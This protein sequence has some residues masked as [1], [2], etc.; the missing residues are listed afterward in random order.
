MRLSTYLIKISLI[1]DSCR[2]S[3]TSKPRQPSNQSSRLLPRCPRNLLLPPRTRPS[4]SLRAN[5]RCLPLRWAHNNKTK[6]MLTRPIHS[7]WSFRQRLQTQRLDPRLPFPRNNQS[8]R[9][10]CRLR[11]HWKLR[12]H[13]EFGL[14]RDS[15]WSFNVPG[16]YAEIDEGG[17]VFGG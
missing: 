2:R 7:S 6:G 11:P 5:P 12:G 9:A 10:C 17:R 14:Y 3:H 13:W 4:Q 16:T 15:R 8:N 1:I